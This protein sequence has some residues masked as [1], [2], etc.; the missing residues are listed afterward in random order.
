MTPITLPKDLEDWARAEVAAGRAA[1]VDSLV[2]EALA[3]RRE[4]IVSIRAK[5]DAAR[6]SIARAFVS[7][8]R[9]PRA[10]FSR[11]GAFDGRALDRASPCRVDVARAARVAASS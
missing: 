10:R 11:F 7:S 8:V 1:S 2:A 5:L 6:A 4:E 9:S 3:A